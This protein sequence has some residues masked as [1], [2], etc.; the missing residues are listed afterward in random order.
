MQNANTVSLRIGAAAALA[1]LLAGAGCRSGN[2][3]APAAPLKTVSDHFAVDVGGHA[4]QLELAVLAS[5][6]EHGLMQR[7]D[8]G[9]DEGMI[10]VYDR[11]QRQSYWMRNTPEALDIAYLGPGGEIDEIYPG[12]PF[13]E[14]PVTSM[15]DQIQFV[16]EMRQ[17]WFAARGLHPGARV[18]MKAVADA[19]RAR[20]FDPAT[21]RIR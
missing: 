14:R 3:A 1:L 2:P 17:G 18:D 9:P 11:P 16:L 10:F 12:Y 21:F 4:A 13:D 7:P 8:L 6:Q 5:E 15:G 19:L 20:G